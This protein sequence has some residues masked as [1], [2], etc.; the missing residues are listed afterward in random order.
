MP[1][2]SGFPALGTI[3]LF[4]LI[5]SP[6]VWA[7]VTYNTFVRLRQLIAESWSGVDTEL[8][9]RYDLIPNLV[10]TVK[11]Y[12]AHEQRVFEEVAAARTRA[13]AS[14]GTPRE[15]ATDENALAGALRNLFAVVEGYPTLKADQHFLALQRELTNTED[16]I[17]AARRFYNANVRDLNTRIQVFPSNVIAGMFSFQ[18]A[19]FFEIDQAV[20]RTAP[21]V[22][23]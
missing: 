15:Q 11:G 1:T 5:L 21:T 6:F 20:E 8:K 16:R 22:Q 3:L 13:Q 17:Q 14:L 9:R 18:P 12:A 2:H 19:E 10:Q 7:L 23:V 4:L